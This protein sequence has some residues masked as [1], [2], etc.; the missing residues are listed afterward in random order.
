MSRILWGIEI[1]VALKKK[2]SN[3]GLSFFYSSGPFFSLSLSNY[4]NQNPALHR[5][6]YNSPKTLRNINSVNQTSGGSKSTSLN[7]F[8]R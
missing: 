2:K 7:G 1:Y 8:Q 5:Q 4:G 6:Q 3:T